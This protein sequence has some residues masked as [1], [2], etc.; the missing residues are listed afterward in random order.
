MTALKKLTLAALA[1]LIVVPAF[2]GEARLKAMAEAVGLSAEQQEKVEAI[3]YDHASERIDAK[4]RVEKARLDLH[5]I[6]TQPTIDEKA[7]YKA[8]EE[9][10]KA[11]NELGK[12]KLEQ[13][14]ELRRVM[15]AEQWAK[16]VELREEHKEERREMRREM[17]G[18]F[19]GEE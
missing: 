14:I 7:A 1:T 3:L 13:L 17:R 11:Q 6:M 4:A 10:Q 18:E 12:D 5:H 19:Q 16:A 8:L 2:A 15:T 9:L